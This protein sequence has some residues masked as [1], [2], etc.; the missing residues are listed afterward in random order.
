[1]D[2]ATR[3]V[4]ALQQKLA[5]L[6]H[7][8]LLYRQDMASEFTKYQE[9]LLR[10]V[11]TDVA[12]Q[13]KQAMVETLQAYDAAHSSL[14]RAIESRSTGTGAGTGTGT[15]TSTGTGSAMDAVL[16]LQPHLSMPT[17][18]LPPHQAAG[19]DI[20]R[21]R[22]PHAREVEFTGVFTPAFLPLLDNKSERTASITRAQQESDE[23]GKHSYPSHT[24]TGTGTGTGID[25][26][27]ERDTE[28][29]AAAALLQRPPTPIRKNTEDSFRSISSDASEGTITR[30]SALRRSS[31]SSK[32][33]PRRVRFEVAG[34]EV[35]PTE[36]PASSQSLHD[37][38]LSVSSLLDSESED[39]AGS[40]HTEDIDERPPPR[41]VSSTQ[42][43]RKMSRDPLDEATTWTTVS[44][45]PNGSASIATA[46]PQ[47]HRA[48]NYDYFDIT[49]DSQGGT[50]SSA[51][52]TPGVSL[53]P[54]ERAKVVN[55][56]GQDNHSDDPTDD[57]MLDMPP[58]GRVKSNSHRP[59]PTML[60]SAPGLSPPRLNQVTTPKKSA[61]ILG[62]APTKQ[63]EDGEDLKFRTEELDEDQLFAFDEHSQSPSQQ[64]PPE[65]QDED[66]DSDDEILEMRPR[67]SS[68]QGSLPRSIGSS[69]TPSLLASSLSRTPTG[70]QSRVSNTAP[71]MSPRLYQRHPF[72]DPVANQ[73]LH[74]QAVSQGDFD[75]FVG[76]VNGRT[77]VDAGNQASFRASV[78]N[79]SLSLGG[80]PRSLSER[81]IMEELEE[82]SNQ[83]GY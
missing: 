25:T 44:A 41:R 60:S 39:E 62:E 33:S 65:V 49:S 1:M 19:P 59:Q 71:I 67:I 54:V 28:L 7:K 61:F 37:L 21:P 63:T 42:L 32:Q 56:D 74:A 40:Q 5:C 48:V 16:A 4:V 15:N 45:P 58:L 64:S 72:N 50:P 10:E 29:M 36:S 27:T 35:L 51:G 78:G 66:S 53:K 31:S 3:L 26:R 23:E 73:V 52:L 30:R 80:A 13:V 2:E 34:E 81:M 14:S 20:D 22:S 18:S 57:D 24:G 9:A 82:E 68:I 8:V 12:E 83:Q 43:L 76:S 17:P 70:N 11:S 6:D 75:S 69:S 55:S 77:G 38:G 79:G 47:T 46:G